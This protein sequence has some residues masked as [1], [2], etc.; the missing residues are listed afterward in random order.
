MYV[1]DGVENLVRCGAKWHTKVQ[2]QLAFPLSSNIISKFSKH[3]SQFLQLA[4][5]LIM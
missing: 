2:Q 4:L 5:F 3:I 1:L